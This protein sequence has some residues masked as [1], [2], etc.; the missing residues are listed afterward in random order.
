MRLPRTYHITV[1]V[2]SC[3]PVTVRLTIDADKARVTGAVD[4]LLIAAF[5]E[6]LAKLRK[7]EGLAS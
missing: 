5:M 6:A 7:A 3:A 1:G 2:D 4:T